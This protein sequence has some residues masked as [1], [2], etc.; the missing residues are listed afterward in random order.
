M[1]LALADAFFEDDLAD[2][3]FGLAAFSLTFLVSDL[4]GLVFVECV[5]FSSDLEGDFG[6]ALLRDVLRVGFVS[7]GDSVAVSTSALSVVELFRPGAAF[8]RGVG[9]LRSIGFRASFVAGDSSVLEPRFGAA[10]RLTFSVE[11]LCS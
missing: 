1:P 2:V 8:L 10:F 4:L 3:F 6:A 11:T 9:R 7:A 5:V